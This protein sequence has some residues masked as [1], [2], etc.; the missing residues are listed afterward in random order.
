MPVANVIQA[1]FAGGEFSPKL[2][3]RV[4]VQ[5]YASGAQTIENFIV[6]PW[7]GL[8]KRGGTKF[9]ANTRGNVKA[10]L[11]RFIFSTTQ[12]YVLEF[13]PSWIRFHTDDG[14][15]TEA[16]VSI[17]GATQANPV[18]ITAASHGYS[19]GDRVLI[20]DVAGM[21]ELNNRE[22]TVANKTANTFELSGVNGSGYTAYSSG[23]TSSKIVEI[24][25]P[26]G[27]NDIFSLDF[28]Q[29]ADTLYIA[30][31][32][33]APRTLV[34]NS[35]T[36]WTLAA[37]DIVNGPF[38]DVNTDDAVTLYLSGGS[39]T[40]Y[41]TY[42]EG[43][44]GITMTAAS[45]LFTASHVGSLWRLYVNKA[46][47]GWSQFV[48][49]ATNIAVNRTYEN[50]GNVYACTLDNMVDD[51]WD[52]SQTPP[53]HTK[54][55]VRFYED[56]RTDQ[57]VDM[58]YIH[59]GSVIVKVTAF[60]SATSV[61]VSIEKNDA[62]REVIGSGNAT[63]FWEEG[64]FSDERGWPGK[65]TLFEERLWFARSNAEPQT[66][67]AS[68]I[69]AYLDFLDGADDDDG[70]TFTIASEQVDA[71]QWMSGGR[72]LSIGTTGGEYIASADTPGKPLTPANITIRRQT[73]YGSAN[74]IPAERV[75]EAVIFAQRHGDPANRSRI[76]REQL[77]QFEND[78]HRSRN[79]NI[80]SDHILGSGAHSFAYQP[81]PYSLLWVLR[82]DG[83]LAALTYEFDQDVIAW[84][85]HI[86]GNGTVESIT[87][88]PGD[89]GDDVWMTVRRTI[90]GGNERA[91]ERLTIGLDDDGALEDATFLDGHLAYSGGA[92]TS[93]SG[94][95]HIRGETVRVFADGVD[96]G[97]TTVSSTGAVSFTSASKVVVGYGYT[98]KLLSLRAEAATQGGTAQ[99]R[100][101]RISEATFRLYQSYGG[102]YGGDSARTDAIAYDS[103]ALYTGDKRVE[104]PDGWGWDGQFYV[105]HDEAYPFVPIGIIAEIRATG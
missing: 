91:I 92:V 49:D 26:Y 53:T 43:A 71:V 6:M 103:V 80:F 31:P 99:G 69:G 10:R 90:D 44:T 84:H 93:L 66:V 95:W 56:G 30:H 64:A 41:G 72:T 63:S 46:G 24:A 20:T 40:A 37:A 47:A 57:Y 55:T 45:S 96:L 23:G 94:L 70:I 73:R 75:G 65:I 36:S 52:P 81:S 32:D 39:A 78:V 5:K 83:A 25:S 48:G 61:T 60:S 89:N 12:A 76:I 82:N 98:A 8:R 4:D 74:D 38:R 77:F 34:R 50:A 14:T 9:V 3:A 79:I 86:L 100:R 105:E 54:G 21:V 19:N 11:V 15:V 35:A 102:S 29:S 88:I 59:D 68:Q 1:S 27:A 58:K 101:K 33:Y 87:V 13:L 104:W 28:T 51:K 18:V 22:F 17:T 62:P 42:A 67:W 7:G 85:R 97:E 16:G 2:L